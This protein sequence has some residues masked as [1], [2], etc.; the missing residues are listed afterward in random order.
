MTLGLTVKLI[1]AR[2]AAWGAAQSG[3]RVTVRQSA[4][5]AQFGLKFQPKTAMNTHL[6]SKITVAIPGEKPV[7]LTVI[8]AIV[9][10]DEL[11]VAV[12]MPDGYGPTRD[13]AQE[14]FVAE[15]AAIY[16]ELGPDEVV[17]EGDEYCIS[18]EHE[19][20][21]TAFAGEAVFDRKDLNPGIRY[22]RRV[23]AEPR[24]LRAD[25][26]PMGAVASGLFTAL[27]G[28]EPPK[29]EPLA[30]IGQ[31]NGGKEIHA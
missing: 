30:I 4:L 15:P 13:E 3:G 1:A 9:L 27:S 6:P 8:S 23:T 29:D 7:Q 18:G 21:K 20:H 24:H 26:A 11:F 14:P 2:Y 5:N 28:R 10:N 25:G 17:Q 22:R 31:V 16:R 12:A 19:W